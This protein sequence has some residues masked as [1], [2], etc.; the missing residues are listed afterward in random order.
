MENFRTTSGGQ[1]L[2]LVPDH[3]EDSEQLAEVVGAVEAEVAKQR[4]D[5]MAHLMRLEMRDH[6]DPAVRSLVSLCVELVSTVDEQ[7]K[8]LAELRKQLDTSNARAERAEVAEDKALE[9]LREVMQTAR[10]L[11]ETNASL[12]ATQTAAVEVV[13]PDAVLDKAP[14]VGAVAKKKNKR[15]VIEKAVSAYADAWK[16]NPVLMGAAHFLGLYAV[17]V[18]GER[19][20]AL[21]ELVEAEDS[22]AAL[23]EDLMASEEEAE[24]L[25][26]EN[27]SQALAL[28]E[29]ESRPDPVSSPTTEV[30]IHEAS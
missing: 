2:A 25:A 20:E 30:H 28:A 24:A 14:E 12:S 11:A 6:P 1:V 8:T 13:E 9:M 22:N 10:K 27:E 15:G 5:A 21:G 17:G 23:W 4:S 16:E 3:I 19:D 7:R 29:A 18:A 26:E